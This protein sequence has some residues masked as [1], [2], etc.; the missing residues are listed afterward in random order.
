MGEKQGPVQS[1][2]E[3]GTSP[4]P[5]PLVLQLSSR[6]GFLLSLA[7][8]CRGSGELAVRRPGRAPV[9]QT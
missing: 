3:P 5:L 2:M 7:F 6:L 8:R 1:H 4:S 9:P